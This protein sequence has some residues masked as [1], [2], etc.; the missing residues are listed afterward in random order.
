MWQLKYLPTGETLYQSPIKA[1]IYVE[2]ARR[3][4]LIKVGAKHRLSYKFKVVNADSP[5]QPSNEA[6]STIGKN[7]PAEEGKPPRTLA[8][9]STQTHP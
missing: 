3:G 9:T 5:I 4:L 2:I 1:D 6:V 8:E 7:V